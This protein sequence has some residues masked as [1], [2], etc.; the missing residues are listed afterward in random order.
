M[1]D[2]ATIFEPLLGAWRGVEHV[3]PSVVNPDGASQQ[4]EYAFRLHLGGAIALADYRQRDSGF[5]SLGIYRQ[6]RHGPIELISFDN[7]RVPP[8][9]FAGPF[10]NQRLTLV[11]ENDYGRWRLIQSIAPAG[12]TSR[13]EL[14]NAGWRLFSEGVYTRV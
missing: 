9:R 11:G 6:A 14:W 2:L 5:A 4:V 10:K 7:G 1:S 3:A 8:E 12:F 13:L